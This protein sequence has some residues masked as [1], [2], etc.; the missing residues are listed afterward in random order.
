MKGRKKMFQ[1]AKEVLKKKVK[2]EKE[3][4]EKKEHEK[5][6]IGGKLSTIVEYDHI[7]KE[8]HDTKIEIAGIFLLA[9]VVGGLFLLAGTTVE[10]I[11]LAIAYALAA[12]AI[13]VPKRIR[14]LKKYKTQLGKNSQEEVDELRKNEERMKEDYKKLEQEMN[15]SQKSINQYE[16][17]LEEI[18]VV[19][20]FQEKQHSNPLFYQAD[21][22]EEYNLLKKKQ[23]QEM[24]PFEE[25]LNE[26]IDYGNVQLE[27][28]EVDRR[29]KVFMK[30]K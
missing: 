2:K 29:E 1:Y 25:F 23:E 19:E 13:F 16:V 5:H 22:K 21:T 14:N 20:R 26:P 12:V 28:S 24:M 27:V 17:E 6:K 7:K 8:I 30:R 11:S 10:L 3:I 9:I 4:L 18:S 15:H